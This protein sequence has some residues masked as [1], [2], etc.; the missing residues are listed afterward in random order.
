MS[1]CKLLRTRS[2][3]P[4]EQSFRRSFLV[5]RPSRQALGRDDNQD[6]SL[7]EPSFYPDRAADAQVA[8]LG[9][10][11][12]R[13]APVVSPLPGARRSSSCPKVPASSREPHAVFPSPYEHAG[14]ARDGFVLAGSLARRTVRASA[15]LVATTPRGLTLLFLGTAQLNERRTYGALSQALWLGQRAERLTLVYSGSGR[16][17]TLGRSNAATSEDDPCPG[18]AEPMVG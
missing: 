5:A 13:W 9:Q 15:G 18:A 16:V 8:D 11:R 7:H 12:S 4:S 2:G 3:R 14:S 1:A 10:S 17:K 6:G